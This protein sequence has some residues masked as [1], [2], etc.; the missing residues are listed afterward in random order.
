MTSERR[1]FLDPAKLEEAVLQVVA[2]HHASEAP[3]PL[4]LVG[5][6]AMQLY[7]SDRLT[8]DLD[9]AAE[10]LGPEALPEGK[11]LTFGGYQTTAPNG[12]PVDII[13][14]SDKYAGL[15]AAAIEDPAIWKGGPLDGLLVARPEYLAAMKMV[16]GRKRD[17]A[18]LDFLIV[19]D[20]IDTEATRYI[21]RN[22]LGPYAADEFEE[23]AL[24]ARWRASRQS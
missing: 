4:V 16:A 7:G 22:H 19:S 9:F 5:G 3:G 11:P 18:D 15:Y 2:I 13:I 20:T 23:L 17:E 10:R 24:V 8:G 14:R 6:F 1:K 12:V 21:I